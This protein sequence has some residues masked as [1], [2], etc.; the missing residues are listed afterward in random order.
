MP[1]GH[2]GRL[3]A[4]HGGRSVR[5]DRIGRKKKARRLR[6]RAVWLCLI[7]GVFIFAMA[8]RLGGRESFA[9]STAAPQKTPVQDGTQANAPGAS[10][11]QA[12]ATGQQ[13]KTESQAVVPDGK[14]KPIADQTANL[15]KLANSLKAEVDKTNADTLS[16]SVIRQADEIEKLA[17]KMRS[18]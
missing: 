12:A 1:P 4:R 5:T 7:A 14:K 11:A 15:L 17:R 8:T 2:P 10:S 13:G 9:Q 6:T 3:L 18:K 16:I